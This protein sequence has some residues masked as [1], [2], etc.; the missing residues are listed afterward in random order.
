MK[1]V[2]LFY[3]LLGSF[4]VFGQEVEWV[5]EPSLELDYLSD[6]SDGLALSAKDNKY[7]LIDKTGL[8]IVPPVSSERFYFSE[9]L[10][11]IKKGGKWGYIDK[12][13]KEVIP[14]IFD[15]THSSFVDGL[16]I[17]EKNDKFGVI[18]K[19]GKNIIPLIYDYIAG[20]DN[21][22]HVRNSKK[23]YGLS[24]KNGKKITPIIYEDI[25]YFF[26]ENLI[27]VRKN[28]KYG[29]LDNSG[30][31]IIDFKFD[32]ADWFSEGL[33]SAG[34]NN[35]YG[36]IDKTG[37]EV[38]PFIYDLTWNFSDNFA[39]ITKNGKW[40]VINKNG[41][42]ITS[43]IY[44]CP[45][46]YFGGFSE[47]LI[48]VIKNNKYG[49]INKS[50]REVI[51]TIYDYGSSFSK[52]S[53]W[54][55][56]NGKWG[57][58]N[59]RG[60]EV[61][62]FIYDNVAVKHSFVRVEKNGKWGVIDK[63][64]KKIIPF[65][66]DYIEKFVNGLAVVKKNDKYGYINI[67]GELVTKI[68]FDYAVSF[69]EGLAWVRK[70]DKIG[71]IRHLQ[72]PKINF[73][74]L[75]KTINLTNAL[76]LDLKICITAPNTTTTT[77]LYINGKLQSNKKKGLG[78]GK[79]SD[80]CDE[81]HEYSV[82]LPRH[83]IYKLKVVSTN[84]YGTTTVTRLVQVIDDFDLPIVRPKGENYAVVIG[85]NAYQDWE[86]LN[87]PK[88]DCEALI[89]VLTEKYHFK[90]EN[91]YTFYDEAANRSD[92]IAFIDRIATKIGKDDNLLV[93]Y[94]GHGY[95]DEVKKKGYWIPYDAPNN[96]NI[97]DYIQDDYIK[98]ALC[99][100]K[101]QN[102]YV[103]ADACY[104]GSFFDNYRKGK[105]LPKKLKKQV[106]SL[107]QKSS[108]RGF[109]SGRLEVVDDVS[110]EDP[111]H[112]PFALA[113]ITILKDWEYAA[114][115]AT[116][117]ELYVKDLVEPTTNQVPN[118]NYVKACEDKRGDNNGQ[119]IFYQ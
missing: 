45:G 108:F 106:L 102:I 116:H 3:F 13:G 52:T 12:T 105:P 74:N 88:N 90:S 27:K 25:G 70:N 94:S 75:P 65:I 55:E 1:V 119:F 5:V 17:V 110:S 76:K 44:D 71:I 8:E 2:I 78:K 37:R 57:T 4:V 59:K 35:K 79:D 41:K 18:D 10:A 29:Y 32:D 14:F 80:V 93:Y 64:G 56:R 97:W 60:Q 98:T 66:Y 24:D 100:S 54:V 15:Y 31:V 84:D 86:M 28:G 115:P 22:F 113:L 40:G 21:F 95:Y 16:A 104:S 6:F 20:Y 69:S 101:G 87:T 85:I 92:I 30:R 109:A 99:K 34:K 61:I 53:V 7:G 23:K 82:T 107:Q 68:N 49:Y 58:I 43:I 47:D 96:D 112:S 77:K 67:S 26:S 81:I 42:E 91:I 111:N 36:Y 19:N 38:I 83:G 51:P 48:Q 118:A 50:G 9:G 62:P 33:A 11:R 63:N 103:I 46:D 72:K 114:L 117:L 73:P 39:W 89:A